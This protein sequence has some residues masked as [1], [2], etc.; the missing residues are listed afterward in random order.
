MIHV[1]IFSFFAVVF[2]H[3]SLYRGLNF[4]ASIFIWTEFV[5]GACLVLTFCAHRV[6]YETRYLTIFENAVPTKFENTYEHI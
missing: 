1:G 4:M 2:L 5:D 3:R 6:L